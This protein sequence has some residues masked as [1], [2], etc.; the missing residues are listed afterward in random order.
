MKEHA[1]ALNGARKAEYAA[2]GPAAAEPPAAASSD[3][4]PS[5]EPDALAIE[6]IRARPRWWDERGRTTACINASAIIERVDEQARRRRRRRRRRLRIPART[7]DLDLTS[8]W[9]ILM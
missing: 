7:P 2:L 4:G 1:A 5:V 3:L 6:S 8:P 9:R